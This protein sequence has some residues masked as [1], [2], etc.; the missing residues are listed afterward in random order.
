MLERLW[1]ADV[2]MV[3][4]LEA[5]PALDLSGYE[6]LVLGSRVAPWDVD[7]LEG[8]EPECEVIRLADKPILGICGGHQLIGKGFGVPVRRMSPEG[9]GENGYRVVRPVGRHPTFNG[10]EEASLLVRE[11]HADCVPS[12]PR[13]FDLLASSRRCQ[14]QMMA[15]RERPILGMQFHPE[16]YTDKK[17]LGRVL[18]LNARKMLLCS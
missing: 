1:D 13:G 16:R 2:D 6:G 10:A 18:L 15:H 9:K 14:V 11:F 4:Y 5:G 12:L 3:H 8:Y 17:T 7:N